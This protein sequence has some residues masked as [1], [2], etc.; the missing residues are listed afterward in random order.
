MQMSICGSPSRYS[1]V[2]DKTRWLRAFPPMPRPIAEHACLDSALARCPFQPPKS[3]V[4]IVLRDRVATVHAQVGAR[5]IPRSIAAQEGDGP[6]EI[7][8]TTHLALR[9]QARPLL[10]ECWVVVENLLGPATWVSLVKCTECGV[11]RKDLQGREH[12][13]RADAIHSDPRMRPFD[14]QRAG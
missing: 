13:P 3:P 2:Q 11:L 12:V 9:N 5:H 6:H 4:C 10:R 14:R 7:F 1:I 8:R